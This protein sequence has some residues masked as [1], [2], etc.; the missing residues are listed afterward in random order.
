MNNVFPSI[1][2]WEIL[3][4]IFRATWQLWVFLIIVLLIKIFFEGWLPRY[5]KNR[6]SGQNLSRFYSVK[7]I[8]ESVLQKEDDSCPKCGSRLLEK[9]GKFGKFLGCSNYPNCRFTKNTGT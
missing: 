3:L 7:N 9:N 8:N 1:N 2:L 5:L 6:K 4:S